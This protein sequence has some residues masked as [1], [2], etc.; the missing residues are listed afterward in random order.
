VTLAESGSP[1][2]HGF[3][4]SGFAGAF[5]LG[6]HHIAEGTD[7]LLFLLTLLLPAPL[8]AL[9]GQWNGRATVGRTLT[10]ILRI[11]TAFTFGHSLTLALSAF[12]LVSLPSRPVE[13]LIAVSILVSAIHAVR[14]LFPGR[15]A[16]I[17][18]SF[19]LIHGL[20]FASVL[21][22]LEVKGWYRL[23]S[24]LGFNLGIEAMQIAVVVITLPPLLLLSRTNFYAA[25][26][27]MGAG[28][29]GVA[30]CAWIVQRVLDQ[31]NSIGDGIEKLAHHGALLSAV[32]WICGALA[33]L[34]QWHDS[35]L[36]HDSSPAY[37]PADR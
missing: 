10:Q 32:L 25:F 21:N 16:I 35:F 8:L 24:L 11:V 12:G 15:E 36:P 17:A 4:W 34:I 19:G 7:H 33:W 26:R 13:V 37:E 30:S 20:A 14:P 5:H 18:A 22:E 23:V 9:A 2:A 29:A 28:L 27:I 3:T 31:P 1:T 6:V